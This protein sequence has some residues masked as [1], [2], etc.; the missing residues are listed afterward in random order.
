M[1]PSMP[2]AMSALRPWAWRASMASW[3]RERAPS[4]SSS[5]LSGVGGVPPA[6]TST[7]TTSALPRSGARSPSC[8]RTR[9]T[10]STFGPRVLPTARIMDL[11]DPL[12]VGPGAGVDTDALAFGDEGGHLD[13]EAGLHLGRLADVG[14]G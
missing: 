8:A 5:R 7:A 12:D 9:R 14:H 13:D 3:A 10:A 1:P 2:M 6:M 11:L 4:R